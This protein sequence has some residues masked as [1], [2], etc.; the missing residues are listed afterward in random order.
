MAVAEEKVHPNPTVD[1][2]GTDVVTVVDAATLA[3]I[4]ASSSTDTILDCAQS[5]LDDVGINDDF[6]EVHNAVGGGDSERDPSP[7]ETETGC[8]DTTMLQDNSNTNNHATESIICESSSVIENNDTNDLGVAQIRH[9]CQWYHYDNMN[10]IPFN[11]NAPK[12][13]VGY[14]FTQLQGTMSE[15]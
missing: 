2:E 4:D 5:L 9:E 12:K 8:N 6:N 3:A 7:N 13:E 1:D 15:Q 14:S 10:N 11:G